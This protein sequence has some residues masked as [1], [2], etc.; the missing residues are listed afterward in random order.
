MTPTTQPKL[1]TITVANGRQV[2]FTGL[3][4]LYIGRANPHPK[5]NLPGS[6][7]GNPYSIGKDGDREQ[8][9]SKYRVWLWQEIKKKGVVYQ[10]LISIANRIKAGNNLILTCYCKPLDCH[11][12]IIK[13]A[14]EWLI[15]QE[16]ND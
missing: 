1:G 2:G 12:D 16:K 6:V 5:Y 8:V 4:K 9:V 14:V 10:E 13:R 15:N 7:L 3:D 11:G